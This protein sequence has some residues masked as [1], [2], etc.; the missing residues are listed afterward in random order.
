MTNKEINRHMIVLKLMLNDLNDSHNNFDIDTQ[1]EHNFIQDLI[2]AANDFNSC[3]NVWRAKLIR[4][5][6]GWTIIYE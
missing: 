4:T 5:K 6:K 3:Q 1:T 2:D